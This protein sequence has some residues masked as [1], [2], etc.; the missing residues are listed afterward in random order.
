M[1]VTVIALKYALLVSLWSYRYFLKLTDSIIW[2][3]RTIYLQWFSCRGLGGWIRC[4]FLLAIDW[5]PHTSQSFRYNI[6]ILRSE[7]FFLQ[8]TNLPAQIWQL[9]HCIS[10][11]FNST[12]YVVLYPQNGDRVVT[13]D[14][15][16]WLHRVYTV[17]CQCARCYVKAKCSRSCVARA[18][19]CTRARCHHS[20]PIR[21]A[22]R[23][24]RLS[25][26]T[27]R[28]PTTC[29]TS[30]PPPAENS[31]CVRIISPR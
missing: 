28:K 20:R 30:S 24:L 11:P 19:G 31:P 7:E 21:R 18:A 6:M 29:S 3:T 16:T 2:I 14:S 22:M 25:Q 23:R 17:C 13:T 10:S 27:T 15:V 1:F 4:V 8:I 5:L 9:N 12:H 26:T